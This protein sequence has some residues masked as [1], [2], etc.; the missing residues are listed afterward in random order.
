MIFGFWKNLQKKA[1][2]ENRPILALAPM[3]DVTDAAFRNIVAMVS[4]KKNSRKKFQE[5][6]IFTEFVSVDGLCSRGR[7]RLLLDLKYGEKERP[8]VAQLFGA[9]PKNFFDAAKLC[10]ELGFDG[11]DINMGCPEKNILKQGACGALIKNPALAKEIIYETKRGAEKIPVSVKT[12]I[13]FSK[14]E[15]ETWLPHLLETQPVA[16]TIHGRTVKEMSK[17]PAQWDIISRAVEIRNECFR[18]NNA[19]ITSEEKTLILGNG[20]VKNLEDA[21]QKAKKYKVD[22]VMIGRAIFGNPW[23]FENHIPSVEEKLLCLL[24]HAKLFENIFQGAKNFSIMKKHFKAY[25]EG[26]SGAKELRARLME[27]KNAQEVENIIKN[28]PPIFFS[29]NT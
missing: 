12:R 7:Q 1:R 20:D 29:G 23:F 8:I 2:E 24:L 21:Y 15:I 14:N 5:P 26:F 28:I 18:M 19:Y 25:A 10:C 6:V 27:T 3:A 9:T 13:G 16:I 4:K 17:V 22:G 11:I